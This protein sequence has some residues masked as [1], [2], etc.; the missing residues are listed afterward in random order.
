MIELQRGWCYALAKAY[1]KDPGRQDDLAQEALIAAW[2]AAGKG[3]RGGN[4][5]RAARQRLLDLSR[6]GQWFG[7]PETRGSR[8]AVDVPVLDLI[9]E[10]AAD[11]DDLETGIDVRA[12]VQRL[13]EMSKRV[14]WMRVWEE[15]TWDEIASALGLSR[16]SVREVW[17]QSIADLRGALA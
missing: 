13:P 5:A 12:A 17:T 4:Q 14:V 1:T 7:R 6:R 2:R 8:S 16:P 10:K 3:H 11:M 9:D 15:R